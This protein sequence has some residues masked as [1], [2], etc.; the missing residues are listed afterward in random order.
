MSKYR[1]TFLSPGTFVS[2]QTT[3][4]VEGD[5]RDV[6]AKSAA[7]AQTI[8]ERYGARPYGFQIEGRKGTYFFGSLRCAAD[9]D[10][11]EH[12]ILLSNMEANDW[13]L[14]V[15][16]SGSFRSHH[17]FEANDTLIDLKGREVARGLH[18]R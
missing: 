16:Y 8:T 17:P 10:P 6:V 13:P 4:E 12:A 3:R 7:I 18:R 14:V 9:L 5:D 2:E 1:V 11:K 15:V